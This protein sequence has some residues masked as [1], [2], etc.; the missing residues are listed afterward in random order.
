MRKLLTLDPTAIQTGIYLGPGKAARPLW[1]EGENI[2]F[3]D[4]GA[5]RIKGA[6][7]ILPA[8][9]SP[10]T[11]RSLL[12]GYSAGKQ[13]V[14]VGNDT[15]LELLE[16]SAGLWAASDLYTWPTATDY[17]QLETWGNWLVAT[18]NINPP[19]VWKNGGV[20]AAIAG[21]PFTRARILRR[22][23]PFLL[24]FNTSNGENMVE[25]CS[26]SNIESWAPGV[27]RAGNNTI[28][29]LESEII[30]VEPLGERIGVYSTSGL[31]I[32]TFVGGTSVWG[33]KRRLSGIGG[34]SS[35][36]IIEQ[37]PFHYG[38]MQN[39]IFK[40]DANSF[41]MIDDPAVQKW[42]VDTVNWDQS[43]YIWGYH[44]QILRAV[45]WYFLNID[46]QWRSISYHYDSGL[47]TKGNLQATA[48]APMASLTLP[49]IGDIDRKV[50]LW[51]QGETFRGAD[52]SFS[53][54][55]KPLDF[56]NRE[57]AKLVQMVKVDGS[58]DATCRLRIAQLDTP[59]GTPDW[60]HD[61]L[62]AQHNYLPEEREAPYFQ[63]E[64]YGSKAWYVSGM[65]FYGQAGGV[66]V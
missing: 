61:G 51:Q 47:F 20:T 9:T 48:G 36:S 62:L 41:V 64:F 17:I 2:V 44:D 59:E 16:K 12:Q 55:S 11:I 60:F 34:V 46:L 56:G 45:T 65:E 43:K 6:D 7:R 39:G 19:V 33:F 42:L 29:D 53:L 32:G 13:R 8:H 35:K 58:W 66:I 3:R 40:T 14:F 38:L 22:M 25:W 37:G 31:A 54:R 5:R 26:E 63:F 4:L 15:K 27:G 24:A 1:A 10:S 28:R 50:D 23:S 49:V 30:A 57:V 52:V 21:I 18:N